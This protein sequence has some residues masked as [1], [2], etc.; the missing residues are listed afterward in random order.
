[1]CFIHPLQLLTSSR[2]LFPFHSP[3]L[4]HFLPRT[5]WRKETIILIKP[6]LWGSFQKEL[7]LAF[8]ET[9]VYFQQCLKEGKRGQIL[10]RN[11][12]IPTL[13]RLLLGWAGTAEGRI[14]PQ[15]W[16]QNWKPTST[17]HSPH[18]SLDSKKRLLGVGILSPA[19]RVIPAPSA[20][21]RGESKEVM[22]LQGLFWASIKSKEMWSLGCSHSCRCRLISCQNNISELMLDVHG[23]HDMKFKFRYFQHT[24]KAKPVK[25]F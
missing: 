3:I 14:W 1:M 19:L 15:L 13:P 5:Q 12:L 6:E 7:P 9:P 23:N 22:R 4:F 8:Q 16:I 10:C 21:D 11:A 18:A 2:W 17:Q 24:A 20:K 25:P